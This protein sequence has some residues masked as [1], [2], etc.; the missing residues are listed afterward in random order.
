MIVL[1]TPKGW[2]GPKEVDGLPTEGT[3]RVTPGAAGRGPDQSRAPRPARGVDALL[4]ARRSCSTSPGGARRGDR[5]GSGRR[6]ADERE[7]ARQR[8][9]ADRAR[10]NCPTSATT[11]STCRS[12]RERRA[13]QPGCWAPGFATSSAPTATASGSWDPTRPPPTACR[14]VFEVT[15]RAWDAERIAGGRPPGAGRPRDGGPVRASLPGLARGLPADGPPR[16]VQLLRGVHPH[17]RLDVQPARQVAEGHAADSVAPADRVAQLPA[18]L[19]RVA[20]GPQRLLAPGPGLHRPRHQQEGGD[21]PRLPAP[22]RQLPAVGGRPL[23]AQPAL[24]QRD[25]RRQAAGARLPDD[26]RGDRALHARDRDLGLG[27]ERPGRGARRG[28][29]LRGRHPHARDGRRPRRSCARRLPGSA[30]ACDQRRRPDAA[31]ARVR[32][33]A[34]AVRRAVRRAVHAR[35]GR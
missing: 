17:R 31:A 19:A 1:G 10:S 32:A 12:R 25:R 27:L 14:A 11:P 29:R 8:R 15:D 6:A 2:T 22:G 21:H 5:A 26:G 13:R 35:R 4:P 3:F 33:S 28:A 30:R 7:P 24:R 9:A 23:P 34:R 16:P 20:P 18:L